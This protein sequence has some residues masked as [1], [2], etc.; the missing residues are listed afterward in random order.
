VDAAIDAAIP[1]APAAGVLATNTLLLLLLLLLAAAGVSS[2]RDR[3]FTVGKSC[4]VDVVANPTEDAFGVGI[5]H[6]EVPA[7]AAED[8]SAP[9]AAAGVSSQRFRIE[10]FAAPAPPLGA[11]TGVTSHRLEADTSACRNPPPTA[12]AEV[13]PTP[14]PPPT[15]GVASASLSQSDPPTSGVAVPRASSSQRRDR[16]SSLPAPAPAPAVN[17]TLDVS[18][19]F[20]F[21]PPSS[22]SASSF[23]AIA[24][25][26]NASSFC[27]SWFIIISL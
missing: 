8:P 3:F 18:I 16:F 27:N 19:T 21:F 11:T 13:L 23:F 25:R 4:P 2:H 22:L 20:P 10:G 26:T 14:L 6:R 17:A 7:A 5:S 12:A 15:I 1:A 24:F 9:V